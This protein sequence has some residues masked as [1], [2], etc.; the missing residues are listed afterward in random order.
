MI[1]YIPCIYL[2][3]Y[4]YVKYKQEKKQ[5]IIY[6]K[7]KRIEH[8]MMQFDKLYPL[9]LT[10]NDIVENEFNKEHKLVEEETPEGNVCMAY[11]EFTKSFFYWSKKSIAYKY[12]NTIA[13][14]Y[15][16]LYDCK[17]IY[18]NKHTLEKSEEKSI[19]L[20]KN[21][22]KPVLTNSNIF[23]WIGKEYIKEEKKEIEIKSISYAEFIKNKK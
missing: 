5:M 10:K 15:V 1:W 16:I 9:F 6:K 4:C 17:D 21:I 23:K 18:I 14:K 2:F 12:L 22:I 8:E 13:R 20:K 11:D 3:Y 19:F 7:L